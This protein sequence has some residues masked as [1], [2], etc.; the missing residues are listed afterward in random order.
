MRRTISVLA[1]KDGELRTESLHGTTHY[2]V[3][4][5]ALVE[6]V[7]QGMNA[8][9]PELALAEEFGKTPAGWNGRPL[10][11][12]HP[13]VNGA[14]VSANSPDVL[15]SY[16]FGQIFNTQL[17]GKK[18]KCEAWISQDRVDAIGGEVADT[19][20]RLQDG[21]VIEI[22]TGL[23]T[24][25][26]EKKGRFN[27]TDYSGI[28]RNIVP[29][30]LAFLSEGVLGACSVADGCGTRANA[31]GTSGAE[32]AGGEFGP[33]VN[34]ALKLL[35]T[36]GVSIQAGMPG[37]RFLKADCGCGCGGKCKDGHV[38]TQEE[39]VPNA[40]VIL[41]AIK[42]IV[43]NSVP[44]DMTY[45]DIA[46][47]LSDALGVALKS[48]DPNT[49]TYHYLATFTADKVVYF[50]Y[51]GDDVRGY[52]QRSYSIDGGGQVSLSGEAERVNLL[53][54]I[55]PARDPKVN[56]EKPMPDPVKTQAEI[57]AATAAAA[58]AATT[59]T[60]ETAPAPAVQAAAPTPAPT[61]EAPKPV[62][63]QSYIDAAPDELKDV[64]KDGLK[65][66]NA[67]KDTLI[68]GLLSTNRCKFTEQEL[69]AMQLEVLENLAEL[70]SVPTYGG[71][72]TPKL[73]DQ[74]REDDAVPPMPKIVINRSDVGLR[75]IVAA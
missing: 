33:E 44:S 32:G 64:L 40:P 8:A 57:D 69:K 11:M 72:A 68:K 54:E 36:S 59:T 73:A 41:A 51:L 46:T 39:A 48:S 23:F 15:E 17:D 2:V 24:D 71:L 45:N 42:A 65:L 34:E 61:P 35:N 7:L 55:V 9:E 30:H 58:T 43:D 3:P 1:T 47:L 19:L 63:L 31:R 66:H 6:G 14:P 12:N 5:V 49:Y 38:H 20:K 18:L 70:A 74:T 50:A 16:A 28:W 21:E 29:D 75:D 10:V 27:G 25:L 22:S 26:E 53:T 4:V 62:T 67:K 60:T 13:V 56:Q 52:Y 37:W